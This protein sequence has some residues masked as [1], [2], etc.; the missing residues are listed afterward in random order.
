MASGLLYPWPCVVLYLLLLMFPNPEIQ[1]CVLEVLVKL[2]C[3][4]AA[5]DLSGS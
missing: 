2:L 5:E 1:V 3:S 4:T